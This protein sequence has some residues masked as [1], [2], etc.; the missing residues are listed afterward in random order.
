MYHN[1]RHTCGMTLCLLGLASPLV[2]AAE[3]PAKTLKI[4]CVR[5]GSRVL[6]RMGGRPLR[7]QA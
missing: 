4:R 6:H 5:V 3:P 1:L 2:V 7:E